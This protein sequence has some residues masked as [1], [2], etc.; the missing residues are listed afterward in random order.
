MAGYDLPADSLLLPDSYRLAHDP[1]LWEAPNNFRPERFL[2]REKAFLTMKPGVKLQN[3]S[4][5]P[6]AEGATGKDLESSESSEST[7]EAAKFLP[8]GL[9]N[10]FCPGA[11]LALLQL[12]TFASLLLETFQWRAE[13]RGSMDLSEAYSFTLT[14]ARPGKVIF[15]LV[16][17]SGLGNVGKA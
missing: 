14:P 4:R 3:I 15:A 5:C 12:R 9:G 7:S 16:T 1:Q 11:P 2:G 8:F 6:F 17:K 13:G 10:R